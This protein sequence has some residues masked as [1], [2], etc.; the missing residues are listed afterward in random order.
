MA[1][2]RHE[3]RYGMG[4]DATGHGWCVVHNRPAGTCPI[5]DASLED[6][7]DALEQIILRLCAGQPLAITRDANGHLK[8]L[9]SNW[10]SGG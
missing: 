8:I 9:D 6:R 7:V 4:T 3:V 10:M 2:C 5:A 1:A